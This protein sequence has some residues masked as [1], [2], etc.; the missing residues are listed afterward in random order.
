MIL[1]SWKTATI[2]ASGTLSGAVDLGRDYE[3]LEVILPTITSAVISV[4]VSDTSG[5][6]YQALV[7]T[8]PT[9]VGHFVPG[10]T[11]GTG[12]LT[13]LYRL[14]G[15]QHVKLLS[16]ATQAAERAFTIRGMNPE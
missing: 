15:F 8:S 16:G 11:A 1:G 4:N 10:T 3:F 5:G 6:T 12:G 7:H 14:G 2:A 9:A 13:A